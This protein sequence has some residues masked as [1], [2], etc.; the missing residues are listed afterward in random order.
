MRH[1][2][3]VITLKKFKIKR[4]HNQVNLKLKLNEEFLNKAQHQNFEA[5]N[6]FK[7]IVTE[8]NKKL[9]ANQKQL[10]ELTTE[11]M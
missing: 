3:T 2:Y 8:V 11:V 6:V 1:L 4:K 10:S 7:K 5:D 9:E